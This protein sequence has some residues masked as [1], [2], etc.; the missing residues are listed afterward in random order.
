MDRLLYAST[1]L[2]SQF[3]TRQLANMLWAVAKC[4]HMPHPSWLKSTIA[5]SS[6]LWGQYEAQHVANM[7]YAIALLQHEPSKTWLESLLQVGIKV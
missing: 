4:G 6:R 2:M 1:G 7:A 3:G 5:A